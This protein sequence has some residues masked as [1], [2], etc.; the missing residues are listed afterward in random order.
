MSAIDFLAENAANFE[1]W[2][3]PC[4][5]RPWSASIAG[6]AGARPDHSISGHARFQFSKVA[7]FAVSYKIAG[8]LALYRPISLDILLHQSLQ[9]IIARQNWGDYECFPDAARSL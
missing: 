6:G 5:W 9:R 8:G 1:T 2:R 4:L 7:A 3:A